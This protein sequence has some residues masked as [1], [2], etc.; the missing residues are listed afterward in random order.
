MS[1]R[2]QL[3]D[4]SRMHR[5]WAAVIISRW[6]GGLAA[7]VETWSMSLQRVCVYACAWG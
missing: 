3:V 2:P 6:P 1:E 5:V 4:S 7:L